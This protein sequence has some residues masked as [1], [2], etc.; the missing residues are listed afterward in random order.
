MYQTDSRMN[1]GPF[2]YFRLNQGFSMNLFHTQKLIITNLICL[3]YTTAIDEEFPDPVFL[4][5]YLNTVLSVYLHTCVFYLVIY[6]QI[7][8]L[9][10]LK[11]E[12]QPT[13]DIVS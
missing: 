12:N 7:P 1:R 11:K 4:N 5:E 8:C 6:P 9:L 10:F 13:K 2:D 3:V